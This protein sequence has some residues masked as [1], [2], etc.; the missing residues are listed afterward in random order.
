[1]P[2]LY[3]FVL[4]NGGRG[5]ACVF[6]YH[7][8]RGSASVTWRGTWTLQL[9]PK[10]VKSWQLA[11]RKLLRRVIHL[12]K[13]SEDVQ[14]SLRDPRGANYLTIRSPGDAIYYLQLPCQVV[15]PKS[16]WQM[17]REGRITKF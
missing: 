12:P 15:E 9:S 5:H 13:N 14:Q 2:K 17:R 3:A 4:W 6:I 1:M 7:V 16:L 11:A 10:V 8:E